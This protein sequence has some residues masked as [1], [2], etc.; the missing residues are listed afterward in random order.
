MTK[1]KSDQRHKFSSP[2]QTMDGVDYLLVIIDALSK[3][4]W[5]RPMKNKT[6]RSL[7][8][9]FGY[10]L[11]EGRKPEKLGTYEGTE[12]LNESSQ[13]NLKMKK[14]AILFCKQRTKGKCSGA[15]EWNS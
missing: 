6:A 12:F 15:S 7:L 8:E 3:Y 5:V 11:S 1:I 10:F 2:Q 4:V 9:A 14:H 13:Q